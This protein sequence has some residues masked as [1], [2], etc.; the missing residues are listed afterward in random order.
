MPSGTA[1]PT[2]VL[3]STDDESHRRKKKHMSTSYGSC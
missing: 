1:L 2:T 3:G